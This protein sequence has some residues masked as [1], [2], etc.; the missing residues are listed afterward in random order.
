MSRRNRT[1]AAEKTHKK[2]PR[3]GQSLSSDQTYDKN[4]C[5]QKLSICV[6][7]FVLVQQTAINPQ[8]FILCTLRLAKPASSINKCVEPVSFLNTIFHQFIALMKRRFLSLITSY[9]VSRNRM[10][11]SDDFCK[12]LSNNAEVF[13]PVCSNCECCN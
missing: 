10:E 1:L 11:R 4:F 13:L 7:A 5:I 9:S 2:E 6:S 3:Q 8:P 12:V